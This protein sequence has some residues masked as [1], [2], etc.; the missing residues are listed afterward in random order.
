V[1]TSRSPRSN[2]SRAQSADADAPDVPENGAEASADTHTADDGV[3][4]APEAEERR[5]ADAPEAADAVPEAEEHRVATAPESAG[6]V[7]GDRSGVGMP[8]DTAAGTT[9]RGGSAAGASIPPSAEGYLRSLLELGAETGRRWDAAGRAFSEQ[10]NAAQS[11]AAE[12]PAGLYQQLTRAAATQDPTILAPVYA[13]YLETL[14]RRY[15]DANDAYRAALRSYVEEVQ[16]AWESA[17]EDAAA[18]YSRFL[19]DVR[20][21]MSA[22]EE[23]PVDPAAMTL[24]GWTLLTSAPSTAAFART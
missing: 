2:R 24:I 5:V 6:E 10:L 20:A 12:M 14:Q 17:Q 13:A 3:D 19:R 11:Q 16:V 7:T 9:S 21:A 1:P 22:L 23:R 15:A 4:V 8:S 18:E